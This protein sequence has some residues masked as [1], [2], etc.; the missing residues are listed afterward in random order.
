MSSPVL[1]GSADRQPEMGQV[2][3]S[4]PPRP[5]LAILS[6]PVFFSA[7]RGKLSGPASDV[8]RRGFR[9]RI[10]ALLT[11][12]WCR[13]RHRRWEFGLAIP[14]LQPGPRTEALEVRLGRVLEDPTY[15]SRPKLPASAR[16]SPPA[17]L[18]CRNSCAMTILVRR[19]RGPVPT[20]PL[21]ARHRFWRG[22]SKHTLLTRTT[23]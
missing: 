10:V 4:V 5:V 7:V 13:V 16:C 11:L 14:P 17:P 15:A 23:S 8:T 22:Y 6:S 18:N 21:R 19:N 9:G 12:R 2:V 3:G 20:G 1:D